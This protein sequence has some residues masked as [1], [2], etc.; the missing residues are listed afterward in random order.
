MVRTMKNHVI[1]DYNV[2]W[3]LLLINAMEA[4]EEHNSQWTVGHHFN[5][6]TPIC[7]QTPTWTNAAL[8]PIVSEQ[9]GKALQ[10]D[11]NRNVKFCIEK[12]YSQ[13]RHFV[14]LLLAWVNTWEYILLG[15]MEIQRRRNWHFDSYIDGLVQDCSISS[16]LAL[17]ILQSCTKSCTLICSGTPL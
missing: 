15:K 1:Y 11:L 8:L 12:N 6:F 2:R 17:E 3:H 9:S 13:C 7:H 16:V 4:N 5:A 14:A 10:W